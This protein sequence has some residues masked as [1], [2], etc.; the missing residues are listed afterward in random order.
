MK[1]WQQDI[2]EAFEQGKT[3][4][5]NHNSTYWHDYVP[6]NQ[7]DRPNLEYGTE[8]N[9]RVKP[10]KSAGFGT[11]PKEAGEP[12]FKEYR[13]NECFTKE[14]MF[15]FAGFCVGARQNDPTITAT[16]MFDDWKITF[17]KK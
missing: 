17:N 4:Q 14:D 6:Q 10:F 1:K 15:L 13:N 16:E 8:A 7:L 2:L 11:M 12:P 9:W 5:A 3:I